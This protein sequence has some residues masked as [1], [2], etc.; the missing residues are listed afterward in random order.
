MK[1]MNALLAALVTVFSVNTAFAAESLYAEVGYL[2]L[3]F[4]DSDG[5]ST[6]PKNVRA[7]V[8]KE[9]KELNKKIPIACDI[10]KPA[11]P[12]ISKAAPG[13]DQA[14]RIGLLK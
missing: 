6:T 11:S 13:V 4:K 5:G 10:D 14:V 3:K 7:V 2:G 1:K 8:G 12:V 9:L